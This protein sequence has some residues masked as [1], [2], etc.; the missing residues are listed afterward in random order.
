MHSI[1]LTDLIVALL[2]QV[3]GPRHRHYGRGGGW[4][5]RHHAPAPSPPAL[6][7]SNLRVLKRPPSPDGALGP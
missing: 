3:A 1:N 5:H 7:P 2:H 4:R 6:A